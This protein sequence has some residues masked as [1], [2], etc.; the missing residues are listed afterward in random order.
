MEFPYINLFVI[1]AGAALLCAA[2]FI[3]ILQ[4]SITID[5]WRRW[6][7][8]RGKVACEKQSPS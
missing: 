8:P 2:P 3:L 1:S 7:K 5:S 6:R 4:A